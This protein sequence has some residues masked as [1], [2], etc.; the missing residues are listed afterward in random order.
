[1]KVQ[2]EKM[3]KNNKLLTNSEVDFILKKYNYKR[4]I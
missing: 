1:M 3:G 4:F 2:G